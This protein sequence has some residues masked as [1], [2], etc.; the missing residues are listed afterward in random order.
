MHGLAEEGVDAGLVAGARALEPGEDVGI[1]ADGDCEVKERDF[2]QG[3][4]RH[5]V[6]REEGDKSRF[7]AALGMTHRQ[8]KGRASPAPTPAKEGGH[9]MSCPY[10]GQTP[11]RSRTGL[12]APARG[13]GTGGSGLEHP[14]LGEF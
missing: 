14:L 4:Q 13:V 1:E 10:N 8:K 6:H 7:L 2:T 12:I 9:D 3:A 5:R 11:Q